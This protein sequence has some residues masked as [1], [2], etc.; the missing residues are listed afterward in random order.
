[1]K[2]AAIIILVLFSIANA[3]IVWYFLVYK[4][5]EADRE[6]RKRLKEIYGK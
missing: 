4:N 3:L 5:R 1:M 6:Y 2:D